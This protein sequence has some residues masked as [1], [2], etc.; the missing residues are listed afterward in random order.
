M[1]PSTNIDQKKIRRFYYLGSMMMIIMATVIICIPVVINIQREYQRKLMQLEESIIDQK[2]LFLNAVIIEKISDIKRLEKSIEEMNPVLTQSEYDTLF[3]Q[4]VR[5]MIYGTVLPDDGYIWI[6]QIVDF[7]G[8]DGYAI[9]L[10]HPNLPETEG[11]LLSTNSKDIAGNHPYREELEGIKAAGEVYFEYYFEKM[12]SDI[13]SHKLSYGKLYE[14]Y[15]WVVATGVYLDDVD[16]LIKTESAAMKETKDKTVRQII[17][18]FL[19]AIALIIAN[20][21]I[22]ETKIQKLI[23]AYTDSLDKSKNLII[24]EKEKLQEAYTQ[25]EEMA[26]TDPLTGLLNRRAVY[27]YLNDELAR[28]ERSK[29]GFGI[30]MCD[31]DW[32]KEINDKLGH[33]AGDYVLKEF[34]AVIKKNLR[35]EDKVSRWGGEEFLCLITNA[36]EVDVLEAAEKIR[37]M[38]EETEFVWES[39]NHSLTVTIGAAVSKGDKSIEQLIALADERLYKGKKQGRNIVIGPATRETDNF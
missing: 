7:D 34:A 22:F 30:L 24:K 33:Q 38:I 23:K 14:P 6:N 13:I 32:F 35:T 27:E 19:G 18:T 36:K 9:R 2:K 28:Y 8:G 15:N 1:S 10:I 29:I 25:I 37:R 11:Q 26:Y 31:I 5:D 4:N 20:M 39:T 12:N 17:F 21:I 16:E 3:R